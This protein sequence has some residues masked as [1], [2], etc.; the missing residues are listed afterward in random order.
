MRR[1][2]ANGARKNDPGPDFIVGIGASAGGLSALEKFFDSMPSDS[3]MAFVVIQHLSPDFKSL[4]DDLL[5]RHTKMAIHRVSNGITLRPNSIYLIPPKSYM[6]IA[7]GKLFLTE[8]E[9]GQHLDLPIDV[10]LSSLAEAAR[11]RAIAVILSGTGSDGSRG[12]REV[13]RAGGLVLVQSIESA[14]FDGMPRSALATGI[15]DLILAPES[16]PDAIIQYASVPAEERPQWLRNSLGDEMHGEYRQIFSLLRGQYNLD[17]SKYK[18]P[19]V[20]RRIQRRMEFNEINDPGAYA[21]LLAR[22]PEELDRL[23]RDLL[24]GVTEFFRDAKAFH[25][26]EEEVFPEIFRGRGADEDIR[27]WSAGC[28]T[29]EEAY[30]LA[31]L[32]SEQAARANFKGNITIFA[33]DVH[34]SSLDFASQ[35]LY[36]AQR[37][38]NVSR[39]RL[40]RF[41]RHEGDNGFRV[42]QVLRKMIVFAPHNLINDPPF[43]RIDLV[44][45]RNLLIYFQPELQDKTISL[46]HFALKLGGILFL[47]SSEG[48]GKFSGEFETVD[49]SAKLFRKTGDLKIAVDMRIDPSSQRFG[50]HA[51]GQA[52]H[53]LTVSLDRQLVH[54]YDMLLRKHVPAGI[55]I[56]EQR[57]VLHCFGDV[58][59]LLSRPEGRFENDLLTL[60]HDDLRIPLSTSLHRAVKNC[61][62]IN[63]RNLH[64]GPEGDRQACDLSVECIPDEKSRNNHYFISLRPVAAPPV[65]IASHTEN[66]ELPNDEIS[67]LLHQRTAELELELKAAKENLQT[68]IEELQT[69]N[70]ELQATNEELL[71]ANE[72]LQSTNE[73][74]HSVNEELY[75]VNAEFE[76]KNKELKQ[77]NQDHENLL[78]STNVGTIYLDSRL[79]IRKFNP[80]IERIF[81]LLPQDI[82]RPI[83]H[84]AYH[85]ANQE[86]MLLDVRRVLETGTLCEK[87]VST[88]D[89][90]WLLKRILPFRT[91]A[92]AIEGVVITY[93]DITRLKVA[94]L[95]IQQL[96]RKLEGKVEE[97]TREYLEAKQAADRASAAKSLFL[98]NMSHE[99]R[100]PMS[101]IFGTIQLL[102]TT[103]L[104]Q[105]QFG[106]LSILRTSAENLLAI[107]DDIL[108]FSKIEAGKVE[109]IQEPFA[110][111]QLVEE[112]AR[113]HKPRLE[114]KRLELQLILE[115]NLPLVLIGDQLRLKQVLSNLVSNAIKFTD[116]GRI[117]LSVLREAE[118]TGNI[119]LRFSI[120]DT[121]VGLR[122][123]LSETVFEPFTQADSSITR[124]FGGTGLGL[125]ICRQLVELMGG[126]IWFESNTPEAG[127]TFHFTARFNLHWTAQDA[128]E[129]ESYWY[130][131]KESSPT[132]GMRVLVVEDDAVN[133]KLIGQA[134]TKF[135]HSVQLASNGR[136]AVE[137][138]KREPV[139]VVF[140][141]VSMPE[142]DGA[143]ATREVRRLPE[144]HPN[145]QV[146][147]I[148]LTAHALEEDK[149]KFL[150]A[151]MTD[152]LTKPF[153]IDV[154]LD[155]LLRFSMADAAPMPGF[156]PE[157]VSA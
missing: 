85:L 62:T 80:A 67:H 108:D 152:V 84:I 60:V 57:Q 68:T 136:E 140:M 1:E 25:K 114:A 6:T 41:F 14:Q 92:G 21:A 15:C 100:T 44:C 39:E 102:E 7:G 146:P 122:S 58:S 47:G 145:R 121:G 110:V 115:P 13:H 3:G 88:G 75:T 50:L 24:I 141:D 119:T 66:V 79:R 27:V 69:S 153:S 155:T 30:S 29:G 150:A 34:R 5:S 90:Q 103:R 2:K 139:D 32:L 138:L 112:V 65:E 91:E 83:D 74:L 148:A 131:R 116:K 109:I 17:F 4:M 127:T 133:Q 135:G 89:G 157:G 38:K 105:E 124:K 48:L 35:G 33:T 125:T 87:E 73:E 11:D 51:T 132:A 18:P 72:E 16:M 142:M 40:A 101:G 49:G 111:S 117:T 26:L 106:Y 120:R 129:G 37:L 93:T 64:L 144:N 104:N 94:E 12:I 31:I 126:R 123:E 82:G 134:L 43:T 78:A 98:A 113:L 45:C 42:S 70:E 151:G 97:R 22:E 118:T 54:D 137:L 86:Q 59:Q 10:F 107:L 77:L 76:L 156:Q 81:K 19:T 71:A 53:R 28:A 55:L 143:T 9:S 52:A 130:P 63:T 95:E 61:A 99:I 20:G 56:N 46:F 96:N 149:R 36:D 128:P 154:L 23:Y 147:I 8:R